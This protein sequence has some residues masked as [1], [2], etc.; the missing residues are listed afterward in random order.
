M[1][2]SETVIFAFVEN[3]LVG[4]K[5]HPPLGRGGRRARVD[6]NRLVRIRALQEVLQF[7]SVFSHDWKQSGILARGSE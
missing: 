5:R 6:D 1:L 2:N 3:R 7:R 4:C